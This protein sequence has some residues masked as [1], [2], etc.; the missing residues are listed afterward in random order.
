MFFGFELTDDKTGDINASAVK[1]YY[2]QIKNITTDL[3]VNDANIL[4]LVFVYRI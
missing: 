4:D 1:E 3:Q 2:R